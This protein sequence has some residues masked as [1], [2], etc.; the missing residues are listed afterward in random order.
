MRTE[1]API[2]VIATVVVLAACGT[3][4]PSL[5]GDPA[6]G[7]VSS[8]TLALDT[9]TTAAPLPTTQPEDPTA[10]LVELSNLVA[11]Y[12][13]RA[14]RFGQDYTEQN[15]QPVTEQEK[16]DFMAG[17]L[18]GL[19]DAPL[20]HAAAVA[21]VAAPSS[22]E[23]AQYRYVNSLRLLYEEWRHTISGF[24]T[25]AELEAFWASASLPGS[26]GDLQLEFIAACTELEETA[27]AAGYALDMQCP[28]PPP[29]VFEVTVEVGSGWI[30]TPH[31]LPRGT[32]L[33]AIQITNA[34]AE[35]IRP[36]VL[37]IFQGD[38][39]NLP[40]GE[41]LVDLSLSGVTDP[42]SGYAAFGLAYPNGLLGDDSRVQGEPPELSP[43][44]SITVQLWVSGDVVIFD[45]RDGEYE[46]GSYLVI[47]RS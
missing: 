30:A 18:D 1:R 25:L 16:I 21:A 34:S 7:E 15:A 12:M 26:L 35:P 41:G 8:T 33:V 37:D 14:G 31:R 45:Y 44:E 36:V 19:A 5:G 2:I 22:F 20:E 43:G 11:E 28:E 13:D 47:E 4:E 27:A 10:Y 40:V 42:S 17:F 32:D 3:S 24:T 29:E 46:A 39:T 23:A 38:P 6:G 9:N